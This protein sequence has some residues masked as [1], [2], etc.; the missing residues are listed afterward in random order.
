MNSSLNLENNAFHKTKIHWSSICI[1]GFK[2]KPDEPE[3]LKI[4]NAYFHTK[5][6]D[7]TSCSITTKQGEETDYYLY[8]NFEPFFW[9]TELMEEILEK[10]RAIQKENDDLHLIHK[11][12]M[13]D[14]IFLGGLHPLVN[15]CDLVK[16]FS[17]FGHLINVEVKRR[18][19]GKSRCFGFATFLDSRDRVLSLVEKRFFP[20]GDDH[21][22]IKSI[23]NKHS[24]G[25]NSRFGSQN[26][27]GHDNNNPNFHNNNNN[28]NQRGH[29]NRSW[30][31]TTNN[32]NNNNNR[33][34]GYNNGNRNNNNNN[35]RG[36]NNMNRQQHNS[37][38]HINNAPQTDWQPL[39]IM[40]QQEQ[41]N[42]QSVQFGAPHPQMHPHGQMPFMHYPM[43]NQAPM[44]QMPMMM[45]NQQNGQPMPMMPYPMMPMHYPMM[46]MPVTVNG[47][48]GQPQTVMMSY[49]MMNQGN[50]MNPMAPAP[51]QPGGASEHAATTANANATM[52]NGAAAMHQGMNPYMMNAQY[53]AQMGAMQGM[54]MMHPN[55]N[56]GINV[57]AAPSGMNPAML[58]NPETATTTA[59]LQGIV[60]QHDTNNIA[61][62]GAS[63]SQNAYYV[64][65]QLPKH[66]K[67]EIVNSYKPPNN[68]KSIN[69]SS[70]CLNIGQLVRSH[71]DQN[72]SNS[73]K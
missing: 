54:Q 31:N 71:D 53:Q 3:I 16:M 68:D 44:M 73:S 60:N 21:I 34:D 20:A 70:E 49:P 15:E 66:E 55:P 7:C 59:N 50:Y 22:E 64:N 5:R 39:N 24:R 8:V 56:A 13:V 2:N 35:H 32:N 4:L 33:G 43:P 58:Q 28:K 69:N 17:E 6:V 57:A 27:D 37:S 12:S 41:Q 29:N 23:A 11:R 38:S 25:G 40:P 14:Q 9:T 65:S 36:G 26:D 19:N 30:R 42:Q 1:C 51:G 72:N 46:Q 45:G 47:E 63:A 10:L 18:K 67:T 48:D 62:S 52:M 61:S